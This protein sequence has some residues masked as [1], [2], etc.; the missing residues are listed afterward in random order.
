MS[1]Y[2]QYV[3]EREG[4]YVLELPHGFASYF[5][6][7]PECYIRD[8]YVEPAYRNDGLAARMADEI[9][10][11]AK[12]KGCTVLTGSVHPEAN[13]AEDSRKVLQFYGMKYFKNQN[14]LEYYIKE[15]K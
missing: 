9:T 1:L 15:L 14:S 13:R 11:I 7:G 4:G 8:I 2:S 3:K 10:K 5:I 6:V 12:S